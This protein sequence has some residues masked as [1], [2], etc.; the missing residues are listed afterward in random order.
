MQMDASSSCDSMNT[1]QEAAAKALDGDNKGLEFS[2]YSDTLFEVFFAG[3]MLAPGGKLVDSESKLEN[4]VSVLKWFQRLISDDN[5]DLMC[6]DPR[7]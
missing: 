2:R 1:S 3:G 7:C 6:S 4:N 5:D